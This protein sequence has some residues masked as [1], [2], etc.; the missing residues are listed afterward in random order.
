MK[1]FVQNEIHWLGHASFKISASKVIYFDPYEIKTSDNADLIMISHEHFD[2]CSPD[3]VA[4]IQGDNTVIIG[5]ED[6]LKK[7]SGNK[8]VTRPGDKFTISG[9]DIEVVPAYNTNKKFH[10]KANGWCGYIVK[11]DNCRIYH[12]GDTDH[13][14]EMKAFR[15]DVVFLPVSGTYVMTSE[16]AA[17]AALEISPKYAFPMHYGSIVGKKSDAD[18]FQELLSGKIEVIVKQAE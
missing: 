11:V 14:P 6:A 9:V 12:S 2:H 8:K 17:K 5:P 18:R 3:D 16:E 15:A 13:I 7:L 1:D 4:K 10:P